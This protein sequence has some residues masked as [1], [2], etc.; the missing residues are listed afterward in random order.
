MHTWLAGSAAGGGIFSFFNII[1]AN[2][3]KQNVTKKKKLITKTF[4]YAQLK[5]QQLQNIYN[6]V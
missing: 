3:Y 4:K 5:L 1:N 6:K 2:V